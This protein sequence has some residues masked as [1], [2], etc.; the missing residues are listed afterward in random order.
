MRLIQRFLPIALMALSLVLPATANAQVYV[1]LVAPPVMPVYEQPEVTVPNSIWTPGYWAWGPQGYYWVPGTY[2]QPPSL[3]MYWTPGYWGVNPN[4]NGYAWNDGYWGPNVGYY[5]GINY[6]GGYYGNGYVGG[7]WY[8]NAF[9]YNTAVTPVD[10]RRVHNVYVNRTVVVRNVNHR[11][12]YNGP[13][14]IRMYPNAQQRV[15]MH[16]RHVGLT[17]VQRAHID[18][19]RQDRN[20]YVKYN[21]GHPHQI[22]VT[23]PLSAANRPK[24]FKPITTAAAKPAAKPQ[25][26][27][28]NAQPHQAAPEH[29]QPPAKHTQAKPPVQKA[30]PAHPQE[31]A[32]PKPPPAQAP[33]MKAP[34]QKAPVAHP[35]EHAQQKPPQKKPPGAKAAK[36]SRASHGRQAK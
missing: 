34:Q 23:R 17:A 10:V 27:H 13:G 12:S 26:M 2:V 21:G 14:G 22:V 30:A 16:E 6:G 11:Y 36:V 1:S 32:A 4:G 35:P 28:P 15:W 25:Q 9:R 33:K 31:K 19:A 5:G 3:G 20:L 29:K 8:G 7:G 24:D 18:E